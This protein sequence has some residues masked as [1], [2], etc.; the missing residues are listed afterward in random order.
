MGNLHQG[1]KTIVNQLPVLQQAVHTWCSWPLKRYQQVSPLAPR[2]RSPAGPCDGTGAAQPCCGS[3][4]PSGPSTWH[5]WHGHHHDRMHTI[6]MGQRHVAA[7]DVGRQARLCP[8]RA[9]GGTVTATI[10]CC[11]AAAAAAAAVG[12]CGVCSS[13]E[14]QEHLL[15]QGHSRDDTA[16]TSVEP[17]AVRLCC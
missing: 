11:T 4:R 14:V 5:Q 6:I 15:N 1:A 12:R 13:T 8:A 10:G 17:A 7:G 9:D 3:L 2:T 16:H